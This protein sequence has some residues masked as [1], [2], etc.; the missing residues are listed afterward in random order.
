M[1]V[2]FHT[3][4]R[5][6]ASAAALLFASAA[7]QAALV[8]VTVT[9]HNLAPGN[10][11]AFAPLHVGFNNGSFD[12]FNLGGVATAP[13]ISV[14]E[15]GGELEDDGGEGAEAVA[16]AEGQQQAN[17]VAA[18]DGGEHAVVAHEAV[19]DGGADRLTGSRLRRM[20]LDADHRA[21]AADLVHV[22]ARLSGGEGLE[23]RELG[24]GGR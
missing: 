3:H 4:P 22:G 24:G 19:A 14:A 2:P 13:I 6:A 17:G 16:G 23:G 12:A 9:V 11:V 20:K 7:A 21:E 15:G 8:D 1:P 5:R 18:A 10:G